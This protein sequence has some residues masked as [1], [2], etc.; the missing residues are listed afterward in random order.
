MVAVANVMIPITTGTHGSAGS[1]VCGNVVGIQMVGV[2]LATST[3]GTSVAVAL[4]CG[5]LGG[6]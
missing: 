6:D 2:T 4:G 1:P 3:V 5:G